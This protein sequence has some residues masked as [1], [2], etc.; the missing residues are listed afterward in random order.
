MASVEAQI[1][2]NGISQRNL[3]DL[4]YMIIKAL[5][6]IS[7]KLDDDGGVPLTT[8]E[9]NVITAI[10]NGYIEDSRGNSIMNRVTAADDRFFQITPMGIGDKDLLEVIYQIFD[11]M[12]TLTEQLDTDVLTDST[13]EALCYTALFT[14][15]VENCKGNTLGNGTTYYFRTGG[16][17]NYDQLVDLLYQFVNSIETLTEQLDADGTVTD[18]DY[19]SLWFTNTVTMRVENSQ[20]SVVGNNITV[21]P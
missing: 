7:Q 14:W 11:M 13:Y 8:Y 19:E 10:L 17:F 12:E 16:V 18:T 1:K 2:P 21:T 3:V 9:A 6:G 20:G 5:Q 4:L 15:I